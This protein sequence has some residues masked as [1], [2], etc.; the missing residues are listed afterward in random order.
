MILIAVGANLPDSARRPA[1]Q[2]CIWAAEQLGTLGPVGAVSRWYRTSPVPA[3]DQPDYINGVVRLDGSG[4]PQALLG[5]LHAIEAKAGR[6][7]GHLNAARVLDLDLLAVD[8]RV[9]ATDALTL[10]HPRLAQ[11]AFVLAPLCDVAP[12]WV[13]PLL[14][15][16]A[17]ALLAGVDRT[18][19]SLAC[20]RAV[21]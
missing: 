15:Q 10:P 4:D 1:L 5:A 3:S 18:G 19:V 21:D 2:T 11:R 12:G 6:A 14:G 20:G 13:H 16:T 17:G 8:D 9:I 7:R